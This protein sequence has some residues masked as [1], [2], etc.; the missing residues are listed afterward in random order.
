LLFLTDQIYHADI[1]GFVLAPT[2]ILQIG[3]PTQQ[4]RR[5]S[6]R[7]PCMRACPYELTKPAGRDAVKLS[8][9]YGYSINMSVGGMLLLLPEEVGTRQ[10]LEIITPSEAR[11]EKITKLG[12]VCWA[13]PIPVSARVNM[14]LVGI[15][16]L[17]EPPA[18]SRPT[19]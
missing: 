2:T 9:G 14:Y 8:E 11:K 15:R 1:I 3:M 19:Q 17:F 4:E 13:H 7:V 18:Q 12:E 10:V 16:F 6:E 5:D